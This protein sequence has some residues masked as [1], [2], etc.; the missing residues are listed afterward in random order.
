MKLKAERRRKNRDEVVE[1]DTV[2]TRV[3][4]YY[5]GYYSANEDE[6]QNVAEILA[7]KATDFS[8]ILF[9]SRASTE[10]KE[11]PTGL[12]KSQP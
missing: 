7:T 3:K 9:V 11:K 6:W 2:N 1:R 4:I 12:K 8:D 10:D 5:I